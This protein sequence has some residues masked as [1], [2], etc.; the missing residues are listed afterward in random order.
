VDQLEP[1]YQIFIATAKEEDVSARDGFR[2]FRVEA[3][4]VAPE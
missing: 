1:D 3:G 4:R 2:R